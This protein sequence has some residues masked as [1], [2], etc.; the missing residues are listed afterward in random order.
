M[1]MQNGYTP[2][3]ETTEKTDSEYVFK[4]MTFYVYKFLVIRNFK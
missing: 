2:K 1:N 4:Q 3:P